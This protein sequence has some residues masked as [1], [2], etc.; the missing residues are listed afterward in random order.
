MKHD[1]CSAEK[2]IFLDNFIR[3]WIHN[4]NK[5]LKD[6]VKEGMIVLDFGCA[7]GFF[8]TELAKMVGVNGKVIAVD[9]QAEML[10]K[11]RRKIKGTEIEKRIVLHK[12]E[13]AKIGLKQKV[14]MILAFY[15]LHEVP[16]QKSLFMEIKSLLKQNGILFIIEPKSHVSKKEFEEMISET[17][18]L[19]YRVWNRPKINF[20]R[21]VVLKR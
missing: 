11:L 6:C 13:P 12:C 2:A 15:V 3:R 10:D 9:L 20:S 16:S 5:I 8:T 1:I 18:K 17:V 14:D 21:A 7:S 4:P 19:G